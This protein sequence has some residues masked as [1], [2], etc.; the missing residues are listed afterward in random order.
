MT[1]T[2]SPVSGTNLSGADVI[3]VFLTDENG[4]SGSCLINTIP[5]DVDPPMITCPGNQTVNN[6]TDC[7]YQIT[8][9]TSLAS[10]SDNCPG[11]TL[12]QNPAVGTEIGTGTHTIE[13]TATD[14][15][16]NS[17]VCTFELTV[18]ESVNPTI[19]CPG[20]IST[21]DPIVSYT[22]PVANDNCSGFS[23]TQT[24]GTGL[25]SGDQFP[26][27][28]TIQS[29]EITDPSG[30]TASCAFNVE[31]LEAPSQANVLT[32]DT[33][34]CDTTSIVIEADP[35]SSGTGEWM[36]VSGS[37]NFN[38]EFANITGVNNMTYGDNVFVW[39]ITSVNC[40]ST[41]DTVVVSVFEEPFPASTQD[42]LYICSDTSLNI[43]ANQPSVGIGTWGDANGN[44]SFL[45]A[46]SPNTL[47]YNF[48]SGWNNLSWTISNGNCPTTSDTL[49]VFNK[50][51]TEIFTGDTSVCAGDNIVVNGTDSPDGVNSIWYVINGAADFESSSNS[52][53]LVYNLGGGENI[54]VFGQNHPICG[55]TL[56]TISVSVGLCGEYDPLIPTVITPNGDGDNDLLVIENLNILY[57]DNEVKIVNRWGGLVFESKGYEE[58][59]NGTRMNEGEPLP[60]G[61]YFY[62]IILND[63]EG[64]DITGPIS[65]IR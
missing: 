35:A 25:T 5:N 52:S 18:T 43:S 58:P 15:S 51:N 19:S 62:R 56:D 22:A 31:V 42:T 33:Q 57:P 14:V 49:S 34:L 44:V 4:N 11:V 55:T 20:N 8:D 1:I 50:L 63:D 30:N 29:F 23:V 54:I 6:G 53:T 36:L 7:N 41:T 60:M 48:S 24:D 65:I 3:E 59:W 61:S 37:G 39:E 46:N 32:E 10:S 9:F 12:S 21:C 2:Q 64:T 27:G 17:A 45:D 13:I 38:N 16:G 40:G 26:V 47:A 28:I